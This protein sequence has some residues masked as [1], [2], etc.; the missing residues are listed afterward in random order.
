M[1]E[2]GDAIATRG[3][4]L[5]TLRGPHYQTLRSLGVLVGVELAVVPIA[6][7]TLNPM[8]AALLPVTLFF[9][10]VFWLR[11]QSNEALKACNQGADLLDRGRFEAAEQVL[12]DVLVR[13]R[14]VT[15][16]QP[17]AAYHRA[18]IE[19]FRGNLEGARVRLV[20]VMASG[21]FGPNRMLQAL[22]PQ[23]QSALALTAALQG[24]LDAAER[25]LADGKAGPNSL[26]RWWY[27]AD[28]VVTLRR[29]RP[30][31]L[32]RQ[33][34][35][36]RDDIEATLSG[37]GLRQ[38]QL[39]EA[40]AL[41]QLAEREDNYRGVHS[42]ADIDALL[43]GQRPGTFDF[44]AGSWPQLRDF[45]HSRRLFAPASLRSRP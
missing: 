1:S 5:P 10:W 23:V 18:R 9:A 38:L 15:H 41:T 13:R 37:R 20:A 42:G 31:E 2:T 8:L 43:H 12:D 17:L 32:I 24:D 16:L 29:G 45:M 34:D 40:F 36:Q 3:R 21:W 14:M 39:L 7:A 11:R 22:A 44:M 25:S 28:A 6:L 26:E 4:D 33:L 19:L 27:L 35:E 30:A